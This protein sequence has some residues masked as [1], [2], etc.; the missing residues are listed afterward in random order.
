MKMKYVLLSAV[1]L[2]S[3]TPTISQAEGAPA[4]PLV[5]CQIDSTPQLLLPEFVCN[6][7]KNS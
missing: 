6:W 3:L 4:M 1:M 5:V 2:L 7:H